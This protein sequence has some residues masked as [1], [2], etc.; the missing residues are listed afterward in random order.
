[1]QRT[2]ETYEQGKAWNDQI[3]NGACSRIRDRR[4][5]APADVAECNRVYAQSP[6]CVSYKGYATIWYD[7]VDD[8]NPNIKWFAVQTDVINTLGDKMQNTDPPYYRSPQYRDMLH[9]LLK[10]TFSPGRKRWADAKQFGE[11]AYRACIDGR[12]F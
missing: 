6:L 10:V 7:M 3:E 1:M 8:P 2:A 9:R 5:D 11:A 4:T 12:P